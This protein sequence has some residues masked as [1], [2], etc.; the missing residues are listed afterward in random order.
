MDIARYSVIVTLLD[1]V[2]NL[3]TLYS[4]LT[5]TMSA[6]DAPYEMI[7]V[8]DG[9]VDESFAWLCQ[10]Q[11]TDAQ[12]KIIKLSR[13]FGKQ[14]ALTAGLDHAVGDAVILLDADLQHD[15]QMIARFAEYW[16]DGYQIVCAVSRQIERG[17][18]VQRALSR[19]F[20]RILNS[21]ADKRTPIIPT[22]FLLLDRA[23]VDNL[24]QLRERARFI[25]G[26]VSW[27]GYRQVTIEFTESPRH[28]GETKF[29]ALKL[30]N[31]AID[32]LT[33]FSTLPLRVASWVGL[34]ISVSSFLY[35]AFA[36]YARFFTNYTVPGWTSIIATALLLSGVQLLFLGIIGEYIARIY[37]EVRQRP[38]YI[39]ERKI[40]WENKQDDE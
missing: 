32:A 12:V 28:A 13:N 2:E 36:V 29:S 5:A 39:I 40:G 25:R 34:I 14:M 6:L 15:P 38:L 18:F 33:A 27:V 16:R 11:Q 8:D 19:L 26:L 31:L 1:E 7:F 4:R 22:D 24:K 21:M 30:L 20:D 3:P 17:G 23:V 37:E 10:T 9:S 35:A